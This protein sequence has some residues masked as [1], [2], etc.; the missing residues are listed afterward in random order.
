MYPVSLT[1]FCS[2]R[3]RDE[4]AAEAHREQIA[5]PLRLGEKRAEEGVEVLQVQLWAP[6]PVVLQQQT[7]S[8]PVFLS[9]QLSSE[10][11]WHCLQDEEDADLLEE[12]W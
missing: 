2:L 7:A 4:S 10:A 9:A 12:G 8:R 1:C 5:A 6:L 11:C 3:D